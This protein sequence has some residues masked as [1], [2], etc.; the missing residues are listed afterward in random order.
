M[1]GAMC[2][3]CLCGNATQTVTLFFTILQSNLQVSTFEDLPVPA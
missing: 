3:M 2:T 1:C